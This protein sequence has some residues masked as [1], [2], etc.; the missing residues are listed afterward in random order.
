LKG[1]SVNWM[2]GPVAFSISFTT[3]DTVQR[4]LEAPPSSS[5]SH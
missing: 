1:V 5:Y 2:K 3:F 4:W